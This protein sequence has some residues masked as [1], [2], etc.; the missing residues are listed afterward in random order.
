MGLEI[1]KLNTDYKEN[2]HTENI[3]EQTGLQQIAAN[4][5][6]QMVLLGNKLM[7]NYLETYKTN[8][9]IQPNIGKIVS[10]WGNFIAVSCLWG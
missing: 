7:I 5:N 1:C 9:I 4:M 3:S 2:E 10:N 6:K 8:Q